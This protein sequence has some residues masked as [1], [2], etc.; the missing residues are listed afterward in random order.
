MTEPHLARGGEDHRRGSRGNWRGMG[1]K[2][3]RFVALFEDR[4]SAAYDEGQAMWGSVARITSTRN[5][6]S[7]VF[8]RSLFESRMR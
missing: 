2:T 5:G 3:S 7:C 1:R 6:R 4:G 8:D